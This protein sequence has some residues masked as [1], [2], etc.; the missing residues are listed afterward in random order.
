MD[1]SKLIA[2]SDAV[3]VHC[4]APEEVLK[5]RYVERAESGERHPVHDDADRADALAKDLDKGI[6]DPL[7]LGIPLIRVDSSDGFDPSVAEIVSRLRDG[8]VRAA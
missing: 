1:L 3:M 8:S 6:Y 7:D 5:Q 4:T 2:V